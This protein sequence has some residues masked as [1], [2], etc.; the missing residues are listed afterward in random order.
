MV[1]SNDVLDMTSNILCPT[2]STSGCVYFSASGVTR[3]TDSMYNYCTA[4]QSYVYNIDVGSMQSGGDY[5]QTYGTNC[6][7]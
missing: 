7:F 2:T 6:D 3:Y 4:D 5:T 1:R